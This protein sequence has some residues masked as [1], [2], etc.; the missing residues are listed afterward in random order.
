V[1]VFVAF[2]AALD[3]ERDPD[4]PDPLPPADAAEPPSPVEPVGLLATPDTIAV[5]DVAPV[6]PEVEVWYPK[7]STSTDTVLANHKMMRLI[8][9]SP[10]E[11]LEMELPGRES[12]RRQ[13]TPDEVGPVLGPADEHVTLG[14]VGDPEA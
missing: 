1:T 14:Q 4:P 12:G 7:S 5:W 6:T 3:V 9:L 8:V 2:V 10:R 13:V 11:G